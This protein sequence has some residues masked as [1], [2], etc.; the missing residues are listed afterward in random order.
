MAVAGVVFGVVLLVAV[1]LAFNS[2]SAPV[3]RD[4]RPTASV[5][6]IPRPTTATPTP[7]DTASGTA[8]PSGEPTPTPSATPPS[9]WPKVPS[10]GK[11][12]TAG[13][14][15]APSGSSGTVHRYAVRVETSAKLKA[16]KVARQL[17]EVLNDPRSWAGSGS[18]RFALVADPAKAD[19]TITLAAPKTAGKLCTPDGG[20]SCVDSGDAVISASWWLGTAGTYASRSAWQAYLVNHAVGQLLGEKRQ[21][22]AKKGKPAPVMMPQ[23]EDLGGCTS[24]PWPFP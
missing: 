12:D 2:L 18:V 9:S 10:S 23:S 3:H 13:V 21:D 19:F 20:G 11:F 5:T 8:T 24:N 22:C 16:D 15:V 6:P 17:A 4:G 7:S 1:V 14:A